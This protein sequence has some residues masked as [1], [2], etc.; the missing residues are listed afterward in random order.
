[1]RFARR[2]RRSPAFCTKVYESI[3][4]ERQVPAVGGNLNGGVIRPRADAG[5]SRCLVTSAGA[6]NRSGICAFSSLGRYSGTNAK[7]DGP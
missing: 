6:I 7:R 1:M 2:Y 5:S 3:E 4:G